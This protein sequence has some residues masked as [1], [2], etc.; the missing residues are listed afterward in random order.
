VPYAYRASSRRRSF[1]HRFL[2]SFPVLTSPPSFS[3]RQGAEKGVAVS[4]L[5]LPR[6][7]GVSNPTLHMRW[8]GSSVPCHLC[9]PCAHGLQ[10]PC[11][12]RRKQ[13]TQVR[14][15]HV[16]GLDLPRQLCG[17]ALRWMA[18]SPRV[19]PD[20]ACPLPHTRGS[21]A[22]CTPIYSISTPAGALVSRHKAGACNLR[23]GPIILRPV[24]I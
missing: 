15:K 23:H 22:P 11:P 18:S 19:F 14:A 12:S 9:S 4:H 16:G 3:I 20:V 5:L 17:F 10:R 2:T 8:F 1:R 6:R 7:T 21:S 24:L 13:P